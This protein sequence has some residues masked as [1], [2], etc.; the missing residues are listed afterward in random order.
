MLGMAP[1]GEFMVTYDCKKQGCD[2]RV[3]FPSN[4][5]SSSNNRSL[6]TKL[7][8]IGEKPS[9]CPKCGKSWYESELKT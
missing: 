3:I 5:D 8:V 9:Q 2:G 4:S 1:G 6:I 7:I